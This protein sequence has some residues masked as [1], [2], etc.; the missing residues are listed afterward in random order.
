MSALTYEV[1]DRHSPVATWL[2]ATFPQY[3]EIQAE[4][5]V[6]A[7]VQ[8]VLMPA[9]VAPGTQGA[10]I[11]FWLRMLVDPQPSIALPLTGLLSGRAPCRRAGRELLHELAAG[12][13]PQRTP[14]G[15]V[16]LRMRPARFVDR[17]DEWWARTC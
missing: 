3:K 1:K 10:A 12:E 7:G 4:F 15:G 6:A 2:G 17:G 9:G 8:R 11:D 14:G 13:A 16:E 5:R